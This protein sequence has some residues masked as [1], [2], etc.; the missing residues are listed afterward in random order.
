MNLSE[1]FIAATKKANLD[2]EKIKYIDQKSVEYV[3]F[4]NANLSLIKQSMRT[5]GIE[6][7]KENIIDYI[8]SL[9]NLT[10]T[11]CRYVNNAFR[12]KFLFNNDTRMIISIIF[13]IFC[14]VGIGFVINMMFGGLGLFICGFI[15]LFLFLCSL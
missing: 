11:D 10:Y 4:L 12:K 2:K 7:N 5:T 9:Y 14:I 8:S 6:F 3:I 13:F 15:L 1:E